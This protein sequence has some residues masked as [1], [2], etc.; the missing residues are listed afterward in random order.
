MVKFNRTE[1]S[2]QKI[3][4]FNLDDTNILPPRLMFGMLEFHPS[5]G[6]FRSYNRINQPVTGSV[7]ALSTTRQKV[8]FAG[9]DDITIPSGVKSIT[10]QNDSINT[11]YLGGVTVASNGDNAGIA[12]KP[13]GASYTFNNLDT[14]FTVYIVGSAA[15]TTTRILYT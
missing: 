4:N 1:F 15:S 6:W 10:I 12:L 2:S 7:T 9:G 14:S 11:L 8:G 3:L 13:Q 5:N